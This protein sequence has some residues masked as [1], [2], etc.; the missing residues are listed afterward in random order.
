MPGAFALQEED[1]IEA[2]GWAAWDTDCDGHDLSSWTP[3]A[4]FEFYNFR[5]GEYAGTTP[6]YITIPEYKLYYGWTFESM[7]ENQGSMGGLP[8]F[9]YAIFNDYA[10]SGGDGTYHSA[11]TDPWIYVN[12]SDSVPT[13][14]ISQVNATTD[15]EW[16]YEIDWVNYY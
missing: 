10:L 9:G 12:A 1:T 5:T 7:I 6:Y 3:V 15:D 13:N 11:F 14:L 4:C 2:W 16:A 8:G